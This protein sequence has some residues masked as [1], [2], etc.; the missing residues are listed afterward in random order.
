MIDSSVDYKNLP[1][2]TWAEIDIDAILNNINE[3]K[4]ALGDKV[5]IIVAAKGNGYGHG[6]LPIVKAINEL[7]IYGFATGNMYE[8]IE[9][10][11]HGIDKPIQLFA[12]NFPETADLLVKYDLMPSFVKPGDAKSFADALGKDVALKVWVKCDTGLGR[13]GLLPEEVLPELEYIRNE[14]SFKI[15]GLYSHIGPTDSDKNPKKDEYN[16]GQISCFNK[17]IADIEAAGFEIPRYQLASTYSLTKGDVLVIKPNQPHRVEPKGPEEF[18]L[19]SIVM[20]EKFSDY[21]QY[22]DINW[23]PLVL[24]EKNLLMPVLHFQGKHLERLEQMMY[25]LVAES[26]NKQNFQDVFIADISELIV[27]EIGRYCGSIYP[28]IVRNAVYNDVFKDIPYMLKN[29]LEYI[30]SNYQNSSLTLSSIAERFWVN[31]SYLSRYFKTYM[32]INIVQ[33]IRSM[34]IFYAK[35]LLQSSD[36]SIAEVAEMVGIKSAS[37]FSKIFENEVGESPSKFRKSYFDRNHS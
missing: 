23:N 29:I 13:L 25:M 28:E 15:E 21:L 18:K 37:H 27:L 3:Y 2:P 31:P 7:D 30:N 33:Y 9:M 4:K 16:E 1:R 34:R 10:R 12:H 35:S 8:A 14:T 11:K 32:G 5:E 22:R 36:M 26:E 6:M 20:S 17:I 24:F 19:I